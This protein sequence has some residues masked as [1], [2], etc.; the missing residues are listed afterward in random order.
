M[1][2][3]QVGAVGRC[4]KCAVGTAVGYAWFGGLLCACLVPLCPRALLAPAPVPI[5]TT[6]SPHLPRPSPR[7]PPTTTPQPPHNHR[8]HTQ[9]RDLLQHLWT[10]P[11]SNAPVEIIQGGRSVEVR[12]VGITKGLAMQRLLGLIAETL[13]PDKATFDM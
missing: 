1:C 7:A 4:V 12:P 3:C 10:G 6:R 13:G 5:R 2:R 8:H 9:A 11:I